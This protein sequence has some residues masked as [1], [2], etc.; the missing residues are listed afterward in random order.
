MSCVKLW[1]DLERHR[2][3]GFSAKEDPD[4]CQWVKCFSDILLWR[5]EDGV[6]PGKA[7]LYFRVFMAP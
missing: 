2:A 4:Q 1:E 6:P 5:G 3:G 7:E